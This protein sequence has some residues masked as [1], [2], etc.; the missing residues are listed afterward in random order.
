MGRLHA[1]TVCN[2]LV[3]R[4][5]IFIRKCLAL[6]L[7]KA[8]PQGGFDGSKFYGP[9]NGLLNDMSLKGEDFMVV[10]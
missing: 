1:Q 6:V 2:V 9:Y 4:L 7:L 5:V 10:P 8:L 3:P